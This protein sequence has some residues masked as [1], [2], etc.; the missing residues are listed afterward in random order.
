MTRWRQFLLVGG[1]C[2]MT[3]CGKSSL[4]AAELDRDLADVDRMAARGDVEQACG[5]LAS[6][7]P[8]LEAWAVAQ[9]GE[10]AVRAHAAARQLVAAQASCKSGG[11]FA[12]AWRAPYQELRTIST[13]TTSWLTIFTYVSML[14]VGIG[15]YVWLRRK[16]PSVA[17]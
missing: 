12:A 5:K 15:T 1:L 3:A 2:L 4:L 10:R 8:T 11:D 16:R 6:A 13:L 14:G 7:L 17:G 9:K